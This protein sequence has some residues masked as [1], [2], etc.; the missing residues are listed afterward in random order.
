MRVSPQAGGLVG[1]LSGTKSTLEPLACAH[2]LCVW[3]VS[4]FSVVCLQRNWKGVIEVTCRVIKW[5]VWCVWQQTGVELLSRL[6][7]GVFCFV[8]CLASVV[9]TAADCCCLKDAISICIICL[10]TYFVIWESEVFFNTVPFIVSVIP[11]MC[12]RCIR[13]NQNN[14]IY[15]ARGHKESYRYCAGQYL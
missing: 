5:K 12:T 1:G 6:A 10:Q 3:L 8:L 7:P 13:Y 9:A 11:S 15:L 14:I 2:L 4:S